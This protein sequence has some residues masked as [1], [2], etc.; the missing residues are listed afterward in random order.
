MMYQCSILYPRPQD[1]KEMKIKIMTISKSMF[2]VFIFLKKCLFSF[3]N[4]FN[5]RTIQNRAKPKRK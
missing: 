4:I 5:D 2:L 1:Q 3:I